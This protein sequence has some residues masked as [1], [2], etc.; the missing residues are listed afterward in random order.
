LASILFGAFSANTFENPVENRITYSEFVTKRLN[1]DPQALSLYS[2]AGKFS[3]NDTWESGAVVGRNDVI[4][5]AAHSVTSGKNGQCV[6]KPNLGKCYFQ[7]IGVNGSFG[8]KIAIDPQTLTVS[9]KYR[10][11]ADELDNDWAVVKL[12]SRVQE[13]R[14]FEFEE[15]NT[16][17][18]GA[19]IYVF[20][21]NNTN[22]ARQET[23]TVC[24]GE[25]GHVW[26]MNSGGLAIGTNCK[27]GHGNSGGA[28]VVIDESSPKYVGLL[29]GAKSDY[30]GSGPL[31]AGEFYS[32]LMN[33]LSTPIVSK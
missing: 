16:R 13:V 17:L 32:T 23:P 31:L 14:A 24:A 22:F 19:P 8:R 18:V 2:A 3:C 27:A 5:I 4:A 33:M 10:C 11:D 21:S 29:S 15:G 28:V 6:K 12:R 9:P 25:I 20:A 1:G 30:L 26:K 7:T